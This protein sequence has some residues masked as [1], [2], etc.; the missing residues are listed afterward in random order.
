M[1][2]MEHH[3]KMMKVEHWQRSMAAR[4]LHKK[5]QIL[6]TRANWNKRLLCSMKS[7][8]E[9][10]SI[11]DIDTHIK[12]FSYF[13]AEVKNMKDELQEININY[14]EARLNKIIIILTKIKNYELKD[15]KY[16]G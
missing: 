13:I 12:R 7:K 9:Y 4:N 6:L 2:R 10:L 8:N 5:L 11:N 14:N 15:S 16:Q 3:Y 1:D